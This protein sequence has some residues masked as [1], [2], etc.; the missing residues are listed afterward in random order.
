MKHTILNRRD[1]QTVE[2]PIVF[3]DQTN[4]IDEE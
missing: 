3:A 4:Q 1:I 2:A